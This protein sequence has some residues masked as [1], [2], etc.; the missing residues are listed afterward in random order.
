[1][2]E[3]SPKI[4]EN[5]ILQNPDQI[6]RASLYAKFPFV[7]NPAEHRLQHG[8]AFRF[9]IPFPSVYGQAPPPDYTRFFILN[10]QSLREETLRRDGPK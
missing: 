1:M 6:D 5:H 10:P 3:Y 9:V 4:W 8:I 2:L 7:P